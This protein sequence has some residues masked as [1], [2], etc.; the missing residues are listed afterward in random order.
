MS[1]DE[2]TIIRGLVAV[3]W[4]GIAIALA[5]IV[6]ANVNGLRV[7]LTRAQG[8]DPRLFATL[9]RSVLGALG[10]MLASGTGLLVLRTSTACDVA[11]AIPLPL[12]GLCLPGKLGIKLPAVIALIAVAVYMDAHLMPL[13]RRTERPLLAYLSTDEI[14]HLARIEAASLSSW[15]TVASVPFFGVVQSQPPL[16]AL[17]V[18][19]LGW[20][21]LS[22]LAT[23]GLT[24]MRLL[25]RWREGRSPT[26]RGGRS[27]SDGP[28]GR[29]T[30]VRLRMAAHAHRLRSSPS[31]ETA[32]P[33]RRPRRVAA[34]DSEAIADARDP[35]GTTLAQALAV[36]RPAV[37]GLLVVSLV[38]NVLM[39]TGPLYMLQVY[40]RVLT[41][42]SRE[43]LVLLTILLVGLFAVLGLLELI[44]ARVLSRL[45]LRFDRLV[46]PDL[47]ARAISPAAGAAPATGPALLRDLEQVRNF[48]SGPLPPALLDL[49]WAPLYWLLVFLLHPLLGVVTMTGAVALI[50]LSLASQWATQRRL[51]AAAE[52]TAR[53]HGLAEAGRDSAETLQAMGMAAAQRARWLSAHRAAL[54][55]QAAAGDTA[56]GFATA[57]RVGRLLLQS[58]ILATGAWLALND[59]VSAGAM[60]AASVITAR[61]LAPVEQIIAQWRTLVS[62]RAALERVRTAL[63]GSQAQRGLELP[64]PSGA[65]AVSQLYVAPAGK[66]DPIVKGV[67][68]RLVPGDALAVI[69]P[70]ASG[71]STLARALV[72]VL[73]VRHGEIRLDGATLGQ[74]DAEAL[75]RHIGYLPQDIALIDG[76]IA[77]NIARLDPDP[78]PAMVI[79][80]ASAAGVHEMILRLE[81]GY[82]TPVGPR[83]MVLSGGQRQRIA[84]ARAL[85]GGPALVVMDEPNANLD[86]EGEQA[87][88]SA[89]AGLRRAGRT[90]VV[91]AHRRTVLTACN[92]VLVLKDGRQTAFGATNDVLATQPTSPP[93]QRPKA[94]QPHAQRPRPVSAQS[95]A[96]RP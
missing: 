17:G 91:M 55:R 67:N 84:L 76:T 33:S 4:L 57:I 39:L 16:L 66:T 29:G 42:R 83:G 32:S 31:I 61:A 71:K 62:A 80:A 45:S 58:L 25:L 38:I 92:R 81:Q 5:A 79:A 95:S 85:Y 87:L 13:L 78:D 1:F 37:A 11:G 86:A 93:Q 77:E 15:A 60:I 96:A 48:V 19:I 20:I 40:D 46:G 64:T 43:T 2:T 69:G 65:L 63:T 74:W 56:S 88:I 22:L 21:V 24:A 70:S 18:A 73:P 6:L 54:A 26:H 14:R 36:C 51:A 89:I 35:S 49:P 34:N 8:A 28:L 68:F 9:H 82:A 52:Q 44:R 3:H 72:G 94:E 27:V 12:T 30:A 41:S 75:G 7:L 90:V 59:M 10:L 47:I 50:G 53:C 23:V